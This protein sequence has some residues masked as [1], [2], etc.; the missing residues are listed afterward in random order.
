MSAVKNGCVFC[1]IARGERDAAVVLEDAD[2]LAFLDHRPVFP[3]HVLVIPRVHHE[4]LL[5][6][7]AADVGPLFAN[8][9]LI[10]AALERGL[11]AQGTFVALNN[12]ISQSVPHLHVHVVPRRPRDG[13]RGFFWPR[14]GYDGP[15]HASRVGDAIRAAVAELRSS[16]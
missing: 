2:C 6:L 13:L 4:T 12:R 14:T 9:R 10:A 1:A 15:D 3:G 16:G 5:D 11:E 8:A 7:P